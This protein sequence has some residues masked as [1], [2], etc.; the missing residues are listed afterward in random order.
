MAISQTVVTDATANYF[1]VMLFACFY[2]ILGAEDSGEAGSPLPVMQY[3]HLIKGE[4]SSALK[5]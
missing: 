5:S 4:G 3:S 2:T 1:L